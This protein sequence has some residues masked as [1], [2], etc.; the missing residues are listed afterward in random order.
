MSFLNH[1]FH[2]FTGVDGSKTIAH[3][4][5]VATSEVL[6]GMAEPIK[7]F[8]YVSRPTGCVAH[9]IAYQS[10]CKMFLYNPLHGK[11]DIIGTYYLINN[12][13]AVIN[14]TVIGVSDDTVI[15]IVT[16]S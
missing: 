16:C 2:V 7:S 10:V 3:G 9:C 1:S 5:K 13:N 8:K 14:E 12:T 4:R 11:C 6:L 15:F